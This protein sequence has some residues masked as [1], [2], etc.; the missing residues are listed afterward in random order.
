M[1]TFLKFFGIFWAV[2]I[3][4]YMTGG[5]LRDDASKKYVGIGANGSIETFGTTTP[6]LKK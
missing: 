6:V 2:W 5:P 1:M 3:I 4:W